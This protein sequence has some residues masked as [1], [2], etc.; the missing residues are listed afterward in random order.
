MAYRKRAGYDR[1]IQSD[2]WDGP[3]GS[4]SLKGAYLHCVLS[5]FPGPFATEIVVFDLRVIDFWHV[6]RK[7]RNGTRSMQ[8]MI[9]L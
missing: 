8:G 7:A 5:V 6:F 4:I 3:G 1:S 2:K 9:E